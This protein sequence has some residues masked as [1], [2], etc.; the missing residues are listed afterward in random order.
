[1]L[2]LTVAAQPAVAFEELKSSGTTALYTVTDESSTAGAFCDYEQ[3][4]GSGNDELDRISIRQMFTHAPFAQDSDV[5]F[6]V[7]F[8][9]NLPPFGDNR[10]VPYYT[11]PVVRKS[12]NDA[13]VA[14]YT[15]SWKVPEGTTAQWRAVL[16]LYWYPVGGGPIIGKAKGR[17]EAYEHR[18]SGEPS[19][20]LGDQ[21]SGQ[22]CNPEY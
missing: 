4:A 7:T 22:W 2:A 10:F 8:T 21:G 19:Y 12:A 17:Y 18:L 6:Q 15:R 9:R 1:M 20:T 11:T 3:N 14:F 5:G 16:K 13:E